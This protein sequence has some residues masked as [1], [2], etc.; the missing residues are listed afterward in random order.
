MATDNLTLTTSFVLVGA[1]PITITLEVGQIAEYHSAASLP[2]PA[3][4]VQRL[5]QGTDRTWRTFAG[6]NNVYARKPANVGET[7]LG[8]GE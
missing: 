7:I 1:A 4:P 6:A 3:D 8:F 5:V 2:A